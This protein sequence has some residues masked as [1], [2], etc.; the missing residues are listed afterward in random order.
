MLH[1]SQ[2]EF[3]S[4]DISAKEAYNDYTKYYGDSDMYN[5]PEL[6]MK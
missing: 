2:I 3:L 4:I 5:T 6:S 1:F